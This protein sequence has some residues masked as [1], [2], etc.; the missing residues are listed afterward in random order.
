MD[1]S[2][3]EQAVQEIVNS[4]FRDYYRC[5]EGFGGF[6][7]RG[8]LSESRGYFCLGPDV[9]CYGRCSGGAPTLDITD[10]LTLQG[11]GAGATI[12]DGN[13]VFTGDQIGRAHV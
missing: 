11:A 6:T 5:P 1:E 3:I 7:L 9:I 2:G 10:D 12:V 13:G 4:P 8:N